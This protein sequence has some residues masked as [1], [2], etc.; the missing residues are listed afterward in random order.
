MPLVIYLLYNTV[1][2]DF[3]AFFNSLFQQTNCFIIYIY[4]TVAKHLAK[5]SDGRGCPFAQV[6]REIQYHNGEAIWFALFILIFNFT[7]SKNHLEDKPLH[8]CK[9]DKFPD[10]LTEEG[11]M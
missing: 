7:G 3:S 8:T 11:R 1:R 5:T 10:R 9:K 6:L 4:A 2:E